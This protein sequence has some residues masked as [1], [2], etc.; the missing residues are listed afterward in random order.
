MTTSSNEQKQSLIGVLKPSSHRLCTWIAGHQIGEFLLVE[1][2]TPAVS[3]FSIL[4]SLPIPIPY[5]IM[6]TILPSISVMFLSAP[7]PFFPFSV[8]FSLPSQPFFCTGWASASA[9]ATGALPWCRRL[10]LFIPSLP[11][12][13]CTPFCN[14]THF[15]HSA[16]QFPANVVISVT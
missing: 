16:W 10:P 3:L 7:T 8:S 1:M 13:P 14:K 2:L 11:P 6:V 15:A 9:A 5:S 4:I 12:F